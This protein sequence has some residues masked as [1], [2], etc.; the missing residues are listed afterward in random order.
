MV[1]HPETLPFG[2]HGGACRNES[3][4]FNYEILEPSIGSFRSNGEERKR[5]RKE[6]A[7]RGGGRFYVDA[8]EG[9]EEIKIEI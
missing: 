9:K 6:I 4:N 7:P 5:Q 8:N 1:F 3:G 2:Y